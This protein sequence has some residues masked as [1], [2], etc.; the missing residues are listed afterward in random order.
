MQYLFFPSS[1]TFERVKQNSE[2][3]WWYE[4]FTAI[5]DYKWRIASPF[6]LIFIPTRIYTICRKIKCCP[7]SNNSTFL[8]FESIYYTELYKWDMQLHHQKLPKQNLNLDTAEV[9]HHFYFKGFWWICQPPPIKLPTTNLLCM[10]I[11][12]LKNKD[13]KLISQLVSFL[14]CL[15]PPPPNPGYPGFTSQ[16]RTPNVGGRY[17]PDKLLFLLF[18]IFYSYFYLFFPGKGVGRIVRYSNIVVVRHFWK[19]TFGL[20]CLNHFE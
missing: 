2:K 1:Y 12:M 15:P 20:T 5:N 19:I 6:N 11:E 3:L 10:S 17:C 13:K 8:L 16:R 9:S 4:R 14:F 7:R 18:V